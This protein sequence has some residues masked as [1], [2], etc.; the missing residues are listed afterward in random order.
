[1]FREIQ[2]QGAIPDSCFSRRNSI[3]VG[4]DL[5]L[6]LMRTEYY[7]R[8]GLR[9]M[10]SVTVW[11]KKKLI[12]KRQPSALNKIYFERKVKKRWL[13]FCVRTRELIEYVLRCL[14]EGL[15]NESVSYYVLCAVENR[16]HCPWLTV[17]YWLGSTTYI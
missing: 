14:R 3:W 6:H 2:T 12:K 8:C 17:G 13:S 10:E 11:E 1:M 9:Q 7:R 15:K 5:H 16:I 4:T